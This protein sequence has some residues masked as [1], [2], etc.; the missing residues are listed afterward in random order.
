[1]ESG[2]EVESGMQSVEDIICNGKDVEQNM[3]ELKELIKTQLEIGSVFDD[4][5]IA[6]IQF[7]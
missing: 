7:K 4:I 3:I 5:S 1:M 2:D 6:A